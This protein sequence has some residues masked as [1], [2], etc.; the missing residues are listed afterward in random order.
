MGAAACQAIMTER[1]ATGGL[2]RRTGVLGTDR[3]RGGM[4]PRWEGRAGDGRQRPP[5]GP[6]EARLAVTSTTGRP[7]P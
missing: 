7:G 3:Q 1:G 6:N 2:N 5:F 4:G